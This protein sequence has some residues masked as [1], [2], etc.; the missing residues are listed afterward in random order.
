MSELLPQLL[1]ELVGLGIDCLDGG[2]VVLASGELER[3]VVE[4]ALKLFNHIGWIIDISV[5][6]CAEVAL[7]RPASGRA[8]VAVRIDADLRL[9]RLHHVRA[10][11]AMLPRLGGKPAPVARVERGGL[12]AHDAVDG[13][14]EGRLHRARGLRTPDAVDVYKKGHAVLS[15]ETHGV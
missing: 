15:V 8:E 12:A 14:A 1:D 10:A 9:K 5:N 6:I 2:G 3:V 7:K 4:P 11:A 13:R